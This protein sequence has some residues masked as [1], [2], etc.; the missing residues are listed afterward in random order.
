MIDLMDLSEKSAMNLQDL[1]K[2]EAN[3]AEFIK[4]SFKIID[5]MRCKSEEIPEGKTKQL[6]VD[7]VIL[8]LD[9][10]LAKLIG[11][12]K[13]HEERKVKELVRKKSHLKRRNISSSSASSVPIITR[14]VDV[15]EIGKEIQSHSSSFST[16]TNHHQI[17][18]QQL[19]MLQREKTQMQVLYNKELEEL[20]KIEQMLQ[21]ISH[22][23]TLIEEQIVGQSEKIESIFDASWEIGI[24]VKRGNEQLAKAKRNSSGF[25]FFLVLILLVS[26]ASL[27]FLNW[28]S[29]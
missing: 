19:E 23:Q 13:R 11:E 2:L 10:K 8:S 28:Y 7:C 22:L 29:P 16:T 5:N 14:I 25:R 1:E 9:E 15:E 17:P 24:T 4:S 20:L 12:F 27:L 6:H 18:Q 26:A 3:A 21:E